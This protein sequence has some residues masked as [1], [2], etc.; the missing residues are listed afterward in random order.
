MDSL[1]VLHIRVTAMY[2]T[3]SLVKRDII[4]QRLSVKL[5][6]FQGPQYFTLALWA[7]MQGIISWPYR[8]NQICIAVPKG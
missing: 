3:S 1:P 8:D 6:R 7:S 2:V 5:P 4:A